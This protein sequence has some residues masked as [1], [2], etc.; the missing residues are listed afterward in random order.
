MPETQ[1]EPVAAG[2]SGTPEAGALFQLLMSEKRDPKQVYTAIREIETMSGQ[3]VVAQLT[4][5]IQTT[6]AEL[7]AAIA[8]QNAKFQAAMAEQTAKFQAAIAEQTAPLQ[9]SIAELAAQQQAT[10]ARLDSVEKQ[11]GRIWTFLILILGTLLGT[12]TTLLTTLLLRG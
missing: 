2:P 1:Q 7:Q 10:S 8:E 5:L 11:L 4:A 9:A 12:L 3:S 6:A